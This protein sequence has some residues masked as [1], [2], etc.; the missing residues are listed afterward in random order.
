M[1]VPD[2][3]L[4]YWDSPTKPENGLKMSS[5]GSCLNRKCLVDDRNQFGRLCWAGRKTT[6][7]E[8]NTRYNQRKHMEKSISDCTCQTLTQTGFSRRPHRIALLSATNLGYSSHILTK[9]EQLHKSNLKL[10]SWTWQRVECIRM[11]STITRSQSGEILCGGIHWC[12]A[13]KSAALWCCHVSK[14]QHF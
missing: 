11:P 14:D 9:F 8:T 5:S 4:M 3:L 2:R 10:F 6:Q 1:L 7:S 13:N 12:T